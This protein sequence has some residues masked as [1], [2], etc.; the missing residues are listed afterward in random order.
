MRKLI[1]NADDFGWNKANDKV[2]MEMFINKTISSSS[3][4]VNGSNIMEVKQ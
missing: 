4:M 3:V 2:I 1:I